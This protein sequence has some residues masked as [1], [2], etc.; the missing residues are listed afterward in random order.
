MSRLRKVAENENMYPVLINSMDD[1]SEFKIV[2]ITPQ[3]DITVRAI[4][5]THKFEDGAPVMKYFDREP[6]YE[7]IKL[8]KDMPIKMVEDIEDYLFL[9][10]NDNWYR[11]DK[12]DLD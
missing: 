4:V 11:I 6:Q 3:D 7:D 2:T 5:N 12:S 8:S 1:P 10:Q 9:Y